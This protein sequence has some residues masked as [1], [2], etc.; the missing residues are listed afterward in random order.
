LGKKPSFFVSIENQYLY[1][2]HLLF[3]VVFVVLIHCNR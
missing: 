1:K 3:K 2:F